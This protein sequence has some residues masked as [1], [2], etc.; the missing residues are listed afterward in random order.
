MLD[1]GID[2]DVAPPGKRLQ[3][4]SLLS[5]GEKAL[6]AIAILFAIIKLKPAP[7]CVLDEIDTALDEANAELFGRYLRKFSEKTQ[8][9]I[10]THKRPAMQYA[11]RLYG[12]T[13]QEAGVSRIV[14]VKID[15][16]IKGINKYG[17]GA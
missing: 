5:G 6:V 8:F 1:A 12:V 7:F 10:V 11:D 9:I 3:G 13:M 4:L 16:A 2:I 15:D 14:S 17:V